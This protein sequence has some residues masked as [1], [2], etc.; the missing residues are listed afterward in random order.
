MKSLVLIYEDAADQPQAELSGRT[1][2]E[3][4]RCP[5]ATRLVAEGRSGT[6]GRAPDRSLP[7]AESRLAVFCGVSPT[8]A[9]LAARGPLEAIAAGIETA[10]YTHAYR[11]DFVTLDGG[12]LRD[13]R[14]AQLTLQ[15]TEQLAQQIQK[16]FDPARVCLAVNAPARVV[17]L[18]RSDGETLAAG[19]A[20]WL[21]EGQDIEGLQNERHA[22]LISEMLEKSAQV[23]A[24][25]TINDVRVDLGENPASALWLWGGGSL[26]RLHADLSVRT[27][28]LTQSAMASGLARALDIPVEPLRDPWTAAHP[29]EVIDADAL[30]E[31]FHAYDRVVVY[32]ESPREFQRGPVRE[33][34]RLLERM[35]MFL[36]QP[37]LDVF[38]RVKQRRFV[39]ACAE[40]ATSVEP[41]RRQPQLVAVWGTRLEP[42]AMECWDEPTCKTGSLAG[43]PVEDVAKLLMGD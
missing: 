29:S 42:D 17:V 23:L 32:V 21:L 18:V 11:G 12:L 27:L 38:R 20:P 40:S 33:K 14:L 2:L 7:T 4:A 31:W 36:T 15:E 19:Q 8:T 1:P 5:A 25:Q 24:N 30:R 9:A 26:A 16:L 6:L 35:D 22:A 39:L 43:A 28:V 34:V 41:A 3:V 13:G 37:L 10:N